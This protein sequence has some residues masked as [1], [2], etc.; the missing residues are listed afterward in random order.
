[1]EGCEDVRFKQRAGIEFL[2][3][4]RISPINIHAVCRQGMEIN[5]LT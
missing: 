3:V 2:A 1:M 4:E 5:V